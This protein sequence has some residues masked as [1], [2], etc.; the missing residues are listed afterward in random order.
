[1]NISAA[2][3]ALGVSP[4]TL[5]RWD[6]RIP[7]LNIPRDNAG[8]R[9]FD[10]RALQLLRTIKQLQD[11]GRSFDTITAVIEKP[12]AG[13]LTGAPIAVAGDLGERLWWGAA[14][15]AA[16]E[17]GVSREEYLTEALAAASRERGILELE[18]TA[19]RARIADLARRNDDLVAQV[20]NTAERLERAE[21]MSAVRQ[22]TAR[23]PWW[24]FW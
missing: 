15:D 22:D 24:R 3:Q 2:A 13:V 5:R 17:A 19:L 12:S 9:R 20:H 21:L 11:Q 16:R 10:D 8:R 1:V 6:E 18:V 23:R 14:L 4:D 7:T